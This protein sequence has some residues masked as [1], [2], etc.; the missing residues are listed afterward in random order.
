MTRNRAYLLFALT[1]AAST[2]RTDVAAA[3]A[4]DNAVVGQ[5]A[6][7]FTVTDV[8]GRTV[9]LADHR[10]KWVVL[11][12]FNHGCPYTKKHYNS[13]NM[14]A[15]QRDY[16]AKG[17]VWIAVVS[18]GP[19]KQGW[20]AS[21]AEADQVMSEKKASPSFVIR[22]TAG[23]LGRLYGART[24]PHLYAIDPK[25]VL[26]YAG[27]I[28]DKPSPAPGTVPGA[29]NYLKAALDAGLANQPI[30]I[31]MTQPYGCDVKYQTAVQAP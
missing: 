30:A 4:L 29:K 10:G 1:V 25:G 26:R 28:D 17:V 7:A 8:K 27:A 13:D 18:S 12:W 22:D 14:Q 6:A 20:H 9:N 3:Q 24:T 21:N 11:E 31:S 2:T 19:G 23:T 15:L 16:T 5:P